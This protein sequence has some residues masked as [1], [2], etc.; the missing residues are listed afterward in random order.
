MKLF[1]LISMINFSL[2]IYKKNYNDNDNEN[3]FFRFQMS[4]IRCLTEYCV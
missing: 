3:V 2:Q 1:K 4:D